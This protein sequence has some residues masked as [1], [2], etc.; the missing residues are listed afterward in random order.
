MN[1]IFKY[2]PD[3]IEDVAVCPWCLSESCTVWGMPN[4]NFPSV[5][6]NTCG[7]VFL[8]KRLNEK[9]RKRFYHGYVRL[10]ETPERLKPRLEMYEMEYNIIS[11][12][13]PQGS[14]LDV[15]CG[16]GKF[17]SKFSPRSYRRFGVEYGAEAVCHARSAISQKEGLIY[18]GGLIDAPFKKDD[19][20]LI[21]FRGVLE[22]L[23]NPREILDKACSLVKKGGSIFITSMPNL[24]CISAEIFRSYWNQHREFEH[25]VHFGKS[26]FRKYFKEHGFVEIADRELYWDTP[27]ARPIE[28]II[29]IAEAIKMKQEGRTNIGKVSPAFWGNVLS[30][31]FKK[32]DDF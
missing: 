7:I 16:S 2:K 14:V 20:D 21:I 28:D 23:P 13:V 9:G 25:I 12:I 8:N 29:Q 15:G 11:N 31:V 1:K 22:H 17:L 18:E 6:C 24:E 3:E 19:F 10:H 30:M 5:K 32:T 27:Y 4:N 26:N